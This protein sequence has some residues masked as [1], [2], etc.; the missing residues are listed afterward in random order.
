MDGSWLNNV[1]QEVAVELAG[2]QVA[3]RIVPNITA[4]KHHI[5]SMDV[6]NANDILENRLHTRGGSRE[7]SRW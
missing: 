5:S 1:D 6:L 3:L 4:A 7:L 2:P